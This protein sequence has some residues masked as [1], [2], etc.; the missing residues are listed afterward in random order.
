MRIVVMLNERTRETS[1]GHSASILNPVLLLIIQQN[2]PSI[3]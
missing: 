1:E 2:V 3:L